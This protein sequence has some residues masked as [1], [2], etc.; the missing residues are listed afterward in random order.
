M[1]AVCHLN[2]TAKLLYEDK[3]WIAQF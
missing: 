3:S 1:C 2:K